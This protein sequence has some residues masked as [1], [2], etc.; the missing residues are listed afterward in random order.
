MISPHP[1]EGSEQMR[2]VVVTVGL[3][4]VGVALMALAVLQHFALLLFFRVPHLAL[5]E[6]VLAL[7]SLGSSVVLVARRT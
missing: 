4:V 5:Y 7:L 2:A 3:L 1:R 6:G